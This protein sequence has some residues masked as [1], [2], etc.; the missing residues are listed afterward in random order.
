MHLYPAYAAHEQWFLELL[1]ASFWLFSKLAKNPPG[2]VFSN[3]VLKLGSRQVHVKMAQP[4]NH[5]TGTIRREEKALSSRL[6]ITSIMKCLSRDI[7]SR[8]PLYQWLCNY[9]Q[10]NTLPEQSPHRAE[11]AQVAR[12]PTSEEYG[13]SPDKAE[14]MAS[15]ALLPPPARHLSMAEKRSAVC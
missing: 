12:K 5:R 9:L 8:H 7:V 11:Q 14:G 10:Q 4:L 15:W 6:F 1:A 3:R 2:F 13:V